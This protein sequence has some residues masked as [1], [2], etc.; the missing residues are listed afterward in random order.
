MSE[1][2]PQQTAFIE[3]FTRGTEGMIGVSAGS[4]PGCARC[5]ELDGIEDPDEHRAEWE[6]G[7]LAEHHSF[8]WRPCGICGTRLGG[9]RNVWHRVD[10]PHGAREIIHEDDMCDDCL[11]FHANGDLPEQWSVR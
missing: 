5:M 9:S 2:S 6:S 8:S 7:D 11:F 10:D 4:C 1:H 3:A